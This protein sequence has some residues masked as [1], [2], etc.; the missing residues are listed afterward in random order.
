MVDGPEARFISNNIGTIAKNPR[1][2][3]KSFLLII[4]GQF[5]D[6]D[7]SLTTEQK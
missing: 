4:F 1:L 7:F 2:S 5:T 6:H 3:E